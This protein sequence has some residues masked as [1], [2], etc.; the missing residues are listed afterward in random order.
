MSVRLEKIENNVAT[1]RMEIPYD[2]FDK[3]VQVSYL[4][5]VSRFNVPGFRKGKAPRK[6]IERFYGEGVFYEDAI[7]E[8]F[9]EEYNNAIKENNLI[10]VDLPKVDIEQVGKNK[11][12]IIK[13]EVTLKPDVKLGQYKGIEVE[14]VE[15]NV[16]DEDVQKE[17]EDMRNKNARLV[18]VE[19]R[20]VQKGDI[21]YI[22]FTGYVDGKPFEGGSAENYALEVGSNTFI[23][24]FEDQLI[25][26]KAGAELDVKVKFP[27]DYGAKDLAGK[28]AT[29]K[30][31]INDIKVKELPALDDEFA[32]EV[33]EFDSLDELKK[34]IRAR[35]EKEAEF[36]A[37]NQLTDAVLKKVVDNASVDIPD[38]M[39]NR[40]IDNILAEFD[41]NMRYYGLDMYRYLR[42]AGISEEQ[43]RNNVKE[44]ATNRVKTTLVIEKV[45]KEE[46]IEVTQ[47]DV[48]K[49]IEEMA[50]IN[51]VDVQKLKESY[52]EQRIEHLKEHILVEKTID[53]L[54]NNSKI[55]DK[56]ED[57]NKEAK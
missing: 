17:L 36:K 57:Q 19:D 34:D 20:P 29:F 31:K 39:V 54:V 37:K 47:E 22:D 13:A 35:L 28:D 30:V 6:I 46:N 8:I 27:E 40:E 33:S 45:A 24:G 56:G 25:G 12:L 44:E 2:R 4:K 23:P 49:E 50:K 55:V 41:L 7:D 1:L 11:D 38:V 42:Y 10:P 21:V 43:F 53:F 3:A 32:R 16:T 9:H 5:N 48:D 14:K 51:N 52:D 15:Y 18:A 26:A